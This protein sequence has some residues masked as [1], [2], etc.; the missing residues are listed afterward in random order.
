MPINAEETIEG[1]ILVGAPL[2]D[3]QGRS[4]RRNQRQRSDRA[5]FAQKAEGRSSS[6]CSPASGAITRDLRDAAFKAPE[7]NS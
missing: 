3:S 1:A 2:F 5:L 7:Q 4:F 6:R